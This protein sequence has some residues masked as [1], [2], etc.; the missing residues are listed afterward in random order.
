MRIQWSLVVLAACTQSPD[1]PDA[2]SGYGGWDSAP[3]PDCPSSGG[4]CS[5]RDGLVARWSLDEVSD[6]S[7]EVVRRDATE[8]GNHLGDPFTV[9]S[10]AAPHQTGAVFEWS[11]ADPL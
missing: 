10:T 8:C 9:R 4:A 11:P 7:A 5:K 3:I 6:G 1:T 2:Y